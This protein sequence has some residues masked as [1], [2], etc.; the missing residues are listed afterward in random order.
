MTTSDS[1]STQPIPRTRAEPQSDTG[2]Q[3]SAGSP[4]S[5]GSPGNAG[6]PGNT[7]SQGHGLRR[8]GASF[9]FAGISLTLLLMAASAPSPF[10]PGMEERMGIS[11]VGITLVFAVYALALLATLLTLG[12]LSDH[13]GRR[14]IFA[15]GFAVMVISMLMFWQ[16]DSAAPLFLAR[17]VQGAASG[18]LVP[19]LSAMIAD[20][21]SPARPRRAS[22]LNSFAPMAGLALGAAFG[23]IALGTSTSAD[24][25]VFGSLTVGYA[26]LAAGIWLLPETAE[27][28]PGA[29][30]S[31]RPRVTVPRQARLLFALCVPAIIAGWAT[32]GLFFS[33]GADIVSEQ[34]HVASPLLQSVMIGALPA[35]GAVAVL[36][37]H[38]RSPRV[39]TVF[40]TAALAIG[41]S[42]GLVA[43]SMSSPW[44]YFAAVLVTGTG[45]GTA[46]MGVLGTLTPTVSPQHRAGLFAAVY[47][48]S[49][50]AFGVPTVL[51]GASVPALSLGTTTLIYGC[52]VVVL[53][54]STALLRLKT[55]S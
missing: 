52:V 41:T 39:I 2:P 14:P 1:P 20:T 40:G 21:V 11:P 3:S 12:A 51:A 6:S 33:L 53:A 42:L 10:Y 35:A 34:L 16:A 29:W 15:A 48:V 19:T 8:R 22:V 31:L 17:A 9:A 36:A 27:T 44:G 7:G 43:L 46:F 5:T 24:A 47:T 54:A 49:Y 45:F 38:R 50:L 26:V 23:G 13:V 25:I 4:G 30:R 55:T 18:M 32:G 37:L 28:R